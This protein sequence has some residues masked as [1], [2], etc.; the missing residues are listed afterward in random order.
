[1]Q[2]KR[3][4]VV[5]N[6]FVNYYKREILHGVSM[7]ISKGEIVGVIG[8][9]GAGKSTF[10]KAI[11][12]LI[13][14]KGG[15]IKGRITFDGKEITNSNPKENVEKGIG[16]L[17]QGGEIFSNLNVEDNLILS[18]NDKS[19]KDTKIN[20][21]YSIFPHI[22][23]IKK[24]RAGL[25]SGGE[26]QMLALGMVLISKPKLLLLD[27][28][29]ASLSQDF[30]NIIFDVIKKMRE[31]EGIS[32]LLVEQNINRCLKISDKVHLMRDG[33]II[34]QGY[35]AKMAESQKV[36]KLFYQE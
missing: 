34:D 18:L 19:E 27:E 26:K 17:L 14:A 25:L 32:I 24:K 29:T 9:N 12:G 35:S 1:M 7:D 11:S 4:L 33:V 28:P 13:Q 8:P 36:E 16:Y 6:L 15:K 2:N 22:S 21:I 23:K 10:L 3:I 30:A 5:D 20:H 31:K